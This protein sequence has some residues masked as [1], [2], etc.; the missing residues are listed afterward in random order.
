M[1]SRSCERQAREGACD[2][3][4]L[5]VGSESKRTSYENFTAECPWCHK[6]SIFN[7]ASDLRTFEPVAGRDVSCMNGDCGRPFRIVGDVVNPAHEMLILDCHELIESK[8]YMNCILSLAQAYEML[9]NLYFQVSLLYKPYAEDS[10]R[11]LDELNRLSTRLLA[12][13]R[14]HAFSDSRALF[15]QLVVAGQGPHDLHGAGTAISQIPK[16]PA[17][18]PGLP[19]DAAIEGVEDTNLIPLLKALKKTRINEVRNK[20][21]HKSAYRPTA[22]EAQKYLKET[23]A[24][25]FALTQFLNLHDDINLYMMMADASEGRDT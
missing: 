16:K 13:T 25:L 18:K 21:V 14:R 4:H 1:T 20:I 3:G 10:N 17:Y 11:D 9:F 22:K 19:G 7:R 2:C 5:S 24:A 8:H 12:K 23:E 6:E 15:L